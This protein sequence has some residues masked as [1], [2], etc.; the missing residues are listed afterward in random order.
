MHVLHL[1]IEVIINFVDNDG[2]SVPRVFKFLCT[3]ERRRVQRVIPQ[4]IY[5]AVVSFVR[6]E[7][8]ETA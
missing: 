5:L 8:M 3:C 1:Q 4:F 7:M 6:E 2:E